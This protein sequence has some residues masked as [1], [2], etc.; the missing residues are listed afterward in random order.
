M[1]EVLHLANAENRQETYRSINDK[2]H[3]CRSSLIRLL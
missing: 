1:R 2:G 3:A